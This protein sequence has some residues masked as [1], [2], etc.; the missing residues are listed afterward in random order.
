VALSD[1]GLQQLFDAHHR[2][3]FGHAWQL[4]GSAAEAEDAVQEAFLQALR[5]RDR[6]EERG[7][8]AGWLL[9]ILVNV[10]RGRGRR[11]RFYRGHVLTALEAA[12]GDGTDPAPSP[13]R[14]AASSEALDRALR[15]LGQAGP[16][17]R[18]VLVLRHFEGRSTAEVAALL[19][20][21]EATVRTR[22]KRA[23]DFVLRLC[24][25]SQEGKKP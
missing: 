22:L 1:E 12:A 6:Y 11:D 14:R 23:R 25:A 3:L 4:T 9:R 5:A 8:A 13:E 24:E 17:L 10:V 19:R 7:Q 2:R 21:P 20:V 15:A 16:T 18:E